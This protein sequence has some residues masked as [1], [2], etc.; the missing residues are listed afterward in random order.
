MGTPL[1]IRSF[2]Y[3]LRQYRRTWKATVMT[4]VLTPVLFLAAMGLGLGHLVARSHG[5]VQGVSYLVFLAPGLLAANSM[6]TG[7]NEG[8][9]PVLGSI[10]WVGTYFAMLAAPLRVRD[11]LVG[12]ALWVTLRLASVSAIFLAVMALFGTVRSAEALLALPAAVLTGLAFALPLMAYSATVAQ[13]NSF[14]VIFRFGVVPMFL[15]SGTFFPVSQLPS[16]LRPVADA[17]PL[18]QG[19]A[20]CRGL[21]LGTLTLASAALH[22]VYLVVLALLGLAVAS[23]TF[24]RRLAP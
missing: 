15:F 16:V 2:E 4:G 6:Q 10:K 24:R 20:L 23:V 12:H 19:V 3:W 1:A 11:V 14:A 17:T 18:W 5:S 8:T 21:D 9:W 7:F 13:E 22:V